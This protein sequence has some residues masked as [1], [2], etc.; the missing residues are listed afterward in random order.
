[1]QGIIVK[2]DAK[3]GYGLISFKRNSHQTVFFHVRD[4]SR[5]NGP[6]YIMEYVEFDVV[7]DFNGCMMAVNITPVIFK[8]AG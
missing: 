2:Y 6:P 5:E 1:M 4:M 3:R 7:N 8:L